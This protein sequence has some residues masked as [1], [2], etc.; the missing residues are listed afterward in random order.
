MTSVHVAEG[1]APMVATTH[2]VHRPAP[3]PLTGPAA[4]QLIRDFDQLTVQVP[5]DRE[6]PVHERSYS[7]TFH[8][9]GH[10]WI[11]RTRRCVGVAVSFDGHDL[12]A[13]APSLAFAQDLH[14]ALR[15]AA[16]PN[17]GLIPPTR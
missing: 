1:A 3:R 7:V 5:T 6:C 8:T 16:R 17:T 11:A 15:M 13:L 2:A 10:S 9:D 4:E 12:P 14:Q